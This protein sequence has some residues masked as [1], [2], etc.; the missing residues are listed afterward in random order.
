MATQT[1]QIDAMGRF[2][3]ADDP[4]LRVVKRAAMADTTAVIGTRRACSFP[5]SQE[6]HPRLVIANTL[7][8][9]AHLVET[10]QAKNR[11]PAPSASVEAKNTIEITD[12]EA[13]AGD[14][15]QT[16]QA[17][18]AAQPAVVLK[19]VE[20]QC[21]IACEDRQTDARGPRPEG[22]P[23]EDRQ[24]PH[25]RTTIKSCNTGSAKAQISGNSEDPTT[26]K[27]WLPMASTPLVRGYCPAR[28]SRTITSV[29][30][31]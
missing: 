10:T 9:A 17:V 23:A 5:R 16:R 19:K 22:Q 3:L 24:K 31:T 11:Y 14:V 2:H 27:I 25:T 6:P 21:V 1:A 20:R 7:D 29:R 26:P 30:R 4:G 13:K 15:L 18:V 8:H 28:L 12:C